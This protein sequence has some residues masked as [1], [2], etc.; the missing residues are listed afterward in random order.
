MK[1]FSKDFA[2]FFRELEKNNDRDWFQANKKR[3]E[4]NVKKPFEEFVEA[5][6]KEASKID[7]EIRI[8]PK[9]AIFRI[10][11]DVRFSKDKSPY[12]THLGAVISKGGRKNHEIPGYYVHA[13]G[14]NLMLGGGA[15]FLS[16]E[17]LYKVRQE[18][19][20]SKK[21]FS[22]IINAKSFQDLYGEIKGEKNKILPKEFKEE[23]KE[24]P[25]LANKQF[26]FMTELKSSVLVKD[27]L[28][29]IVRK[30]F[31]AGKK[32]NEFLSRAMYD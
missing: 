7:P 28:L 26:Y 2:L 11:R 10:H 16:K 18:I 17:M 31:K 3:Y 27:D 29:A 13:S 24:M 19:S 6:I 21:E 9:E 5:C 22:K 1:Y 20:Y 15:Y 23:A 25:I 8:T 32:F 14:K 4:T 12:K 30:Y